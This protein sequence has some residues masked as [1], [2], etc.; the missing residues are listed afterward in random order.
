[1]FR[2]VNSCS[3]YFDRAEALMPFVADIAKDLGLLKKPVTVMLVD[4]DEITDGYYPGGANYPGKNHS[5]VIVYL[6]D[7][8]HMPEA[9]MK[10][11]IAHEMR[12]A[13][14]TSYGVS[15][16]SNG[17]KTYEE[18]RKGHDSFPEEIDADNYAEQVSGFD[19]VSWWKRLEEEEK[20]NARREETQA[21]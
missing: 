9:A 21:E 1:M 5:F 10:N 15:F 20:E 4:Y 16:P 3:Y 19:G 12:H 14:Q 7:E 8:E 18:Y 11:M 6:W 13:F 2:A 17:A